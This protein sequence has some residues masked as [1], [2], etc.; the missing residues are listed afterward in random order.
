[1]PY[2]SKRYHSKDFVEYTPYYCLG[3]HLFLWLVLL[4]SSSSP[5]TL[6]NQTVTT[7]VVDGKTVA[8]LEPIVLKKNYMGAHRIDVKPIMR[9]QTFLNYEIQLQDQTGKV[10]VSAI[11]PAWINNRSAIDGDLLGRIDFRVS[12]RRQKLTPVIVVL[13]YFDD[14]GRPLYQ[15]ALQ[16][17]SSNQKVYANIRFR[18]KIVDGVIDT[19]HIWMGI[20]GTLLMTILC[21]YS[22]RKTGELVIEKDIYKNYFT[23]IAEFK[24][25]NKLVEVKVKFIVDGILPDNLLI[26]L[27]VC[28][29][30]D[31]LFYHD[32]E[33]II[34]LNSLLEYPSDAKI[35]ER[36]GNHIFYFLLPKP[37]KYTFHIRLNSHECFKPTY[38]WV[39]EGVKTL[40]GVDIIEITESKEI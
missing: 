14:I 8:K 19:N 21:F 10:V 12:Q 39:K 34:Y 2:I 9:N 22:V 35:L 3:I 1:M 33:K 23:A 27:W 25:P 13:G 38:L 18:I 37:G 7:K 29:N 40:S 28:D 6:V 36:I 20:I 24:D 17:N 16:N 30:N 4:F 15:D 31:Q 5:Q 11:K 32:E 26:S